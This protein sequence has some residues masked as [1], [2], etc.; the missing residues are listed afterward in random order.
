MTVLGAGGLRYA[1]GF[2]LPETPIEVTGDED[3]LL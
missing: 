1:G 3:E 2:K